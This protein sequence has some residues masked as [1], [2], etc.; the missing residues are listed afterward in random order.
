MCFLPHNKVENGQNLEQQHMN[1][2][3][4]NPFIRKQYKKGKRFRARQVSDGPSF[5]RRGWRIF[6]D[7]QVVY[8]F[9][10]F[11]IFL[12]LDYTMF[13]VTL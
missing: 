5:L 4:D 1:P 3:G 6:L 10:L 13:L 2:F 8:F 7:R 9:S 11:C 12:L